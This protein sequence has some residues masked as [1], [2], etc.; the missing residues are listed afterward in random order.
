MTVQNIP[1]LFLASSSH[2]L[3]IMAFKWRS[4]RTLKGKASLIG[5]L[6]FAG[7]VILG[8]AYFGTLLQTVIT[9]SRF[10]IENEQRAMI[11]NWLYVFMREG[12]GDL[13]G[14][15][16][17]AL[18][19]GILVLPLIGYSFSS[20]VPEGDLVSVRPSE[21]HKITDSI[22]LQFMSTISFVQLLLLTAFHSLAS[23]GSPTPAVF[24]LMGWAVWI[25]SILA[26]VIAA[27]GFE[28]LLRKFGIVSKVVSISVIGV[29][30]L[31][32]VLVNPDNFLS[33]FGFA[34]TYLTWV[35]D[36]AASGNPLVF[37]G[38]FFAWLLLVGVLL[39]GIT[40][41]ADMS[42]RQPEREGS[43]KAVKVLSAKLNLTERIKV[44]NQWQ[45]YV[46]MVFRQ[47]NLSKPFLT[48]V[49][50]IALTALFTYPLYSNLTTVTII[51][52]LMVSLI[53]TINC[54]GILGSSLSWL[55]SLPTAKRD[56][57]KNLLAVGWVLSAIIA[58][59]TGIVVAVFHQ[60]PADVWIT[61]VFTVIA[62]T[63]V[64]QQYSLEQ[65]VNHPHRF[66]VNI[67]GE[68]SLPPDKAFTNIIVLFAL[69]GVVSAIVA[70]VGPSIAPFLTEMPDLVSEIGGP[71]VLTG[72]VLLACW[73]R[74]R[75]LSNKW[76]QDSDLSQNILKK[77]GLS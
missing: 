34:E 42:L 23:I 31:V 44:S 43:R 41:V 28:G 48:S 8:S 50:F 39:F 2:T 11:L 27:W 32:L 55:T 12:V 37:A 47:P 75:L 51:I 68:S 3:D 30:G 76:L 38:I 59:V 54:F 62:A 77:V 45:F 58:T 49:G 60:P 66:R 15:L 56:L 7:L 9:P 46:A 4:I 33:M 74:F 36:I 19:G 53:W 52:P 65:A 63:A 40:W 14:G 70:T 72:L 25:V 24:I 6:L 16:L 73:L 1:K 20:F 13:F 71:L 21:K 64:G 61:Y 29:V 5:I 26:S 22:A 17:W 18:V 67:R 10:G 57:L 69:S 35:S